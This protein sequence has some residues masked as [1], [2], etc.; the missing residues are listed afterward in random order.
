MNGIWA[1]KDTDC[2]EERRKE[3]GTFK[4]VGHLVLESFRDCFGFVCLSLLLPSRCYNKKMSTVT[5]NS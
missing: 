2:A 1:D 4:E 5:V 3:P